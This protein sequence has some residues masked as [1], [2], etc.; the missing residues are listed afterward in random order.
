VELWTEVASREAKPSGAGWQ[1]ATGSNGGAT[2]L[3]GTEG[4]RKG[5]TCE[6]HMSVTREREGSVA[7]WCKPKEKAHSCEGTMGRVGLLD[8]RGRWRPGKG[9]GPARLPGMT[10]P[11][12]KESLTSDLIFEFQWILEFSKTLRNFTRRF[13]RNFDM[14]IFPKFF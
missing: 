3:G 8:Q 6:T 10:R 7:G 13:R 2:G 11:E 12:S 9:S 1:G 5:L 14:R 4:R